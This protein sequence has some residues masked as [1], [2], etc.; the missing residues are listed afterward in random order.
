MRYLVTA[1]TLRLRKGPSL[2]DPIITSL[3]HGQVVE[4]T[5]QTN[6]DWWQVSV[7]LNGAAHSGYVAAKY[8]ALPSQPPVDVNPHN[9]PAVHYPASPSSNRNSINARHCPLSEADAPRRNIA[10]GTDA[11]SKI[12]GIYRIIKF[13]DVEHS[14]RY[15]KTTQ[16][17]YCNIYAYDFCEL[18]QAY[19]PRVWWTSKTLMDFAKLNGHNPAPAYAKNVLELNA[20]SL[21]DWFNEWSDDFGWTRTYDLTDLQNKVNQGR[22][23]IVCAKRKNVSRSGHIT[24]V[25]PEANGYSAVRNGAVVVAPLQSQAGAKNRSYFSDNWWGR[26]SSEFSNVGYWWHE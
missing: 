17:T 8:L 2:N 25:I 14:L 6:T 13:L 3:P 10:P 24:C 23:G 1:T 11:E 21:Y 9:V 20:N 26:L 15:Q 18:A 19:M 5:N 22:V 7:S 12:A 16:S 4:V